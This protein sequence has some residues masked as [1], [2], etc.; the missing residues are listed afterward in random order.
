MISG[1]KVPCDPSIEEDLEK[2]RGDQEDVET[3]PRAEQRWGFVEFGALWIV[4]WVLHQSILVGE[5]LCGYLRLGI[6]VFLWVVGCG[7]AWKLAY[8]RAD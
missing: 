1:R 2:Q 8:R 6:K 5:R 3:F 4:G 7:K